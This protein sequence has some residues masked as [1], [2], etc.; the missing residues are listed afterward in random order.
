[1]SISS[2]FK[3]VTPAPLT[4][5]MQ[6][7]DA[8]IYMYRAMDLMGWI[9]P[10]DGLARYI[11][12][13]WTCVPFLCATF[14]LNLCFLLSYIMDYHNYST[15][16]FITS[17]PVSINAVGSSV[18]ATI[19]FI[20]LWRLRETEL[21]F[22]KLDH[23]RTSDHDREKIHQ[24]VATCNKIMLVFISVYGTYVSGTFI[25]YA[26]S[27][28]PPWSIYN[29]FFNWRDSILTLWIQ[30]TVEYILMS[31]AGMHNL[32]SDTYGVVFLLIFRKHAELLKDHV[33][34]LRTDTTK[35]EQQNYEDLISCISEHRLIVGCCSWMRPIISATILV[36][37]LLIGVILGLT[38]INIFFFSNFWRGLSS[39][40][41]LIA[42][43]METFPFCYICNLLIEDSDDLSRAIFESNW[44][45]ADQE[46]K[47]ALIYFMLNAQK[48]IIFL[49]GGVL[50]I[51]VRTN[52]QV[53][54]F[55]FSII[56]VVRQ[57][58]LVEKF[59]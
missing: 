19:L 28:R 7:R 18:K 55:A 27:G 41:Y 59:Q 20:Y 39:F 22:D 29:P 21:L 15:G 34:R 6:S 44:I 50:P 10:K 1:M 17:L 3:L 12:L 35:T 46:Y 53:A 2:L 45:D 24:L 49:A 23:Q 32:L 37:F 54:K 36:Q 38:L 8:C 31:F 51:T 4:E 13:I 56:T 25:A 42:V 48:P 52:L 47:S 16:Q 9:P 43:L 14:S 30:S 40:T 33:N 58:N 11:Y 5:K 26:L 57:T